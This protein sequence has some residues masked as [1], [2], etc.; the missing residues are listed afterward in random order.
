[1]NEKLADKAIDV[2]LEAEGWARIGSILVRGRRV[3][4]SGTNM[5]KTHPVQAEYAKKTGNSRRIYLH[6]ELRTLIRA[7]KPGDTMYVARVSK[8]GDSLRMAKPCELCQYA[9]EDQNVET[10]FYT[11]TN[12]WERLDLA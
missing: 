3:V 9:L 7:K 8:N 10:V 2:A 12:G 4:S 6:S 5:M 11:T 1:M